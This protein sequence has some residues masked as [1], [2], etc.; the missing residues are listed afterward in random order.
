MKNFFFARLI[1]GTA[2]VFVLGGCASTK[3]I[4]FIREKKLS[5]ALTLPSE[6]DRREVLG[7]SRQ[8][9]AVSDEYGRTSYVMNAVRDDVTGEMTATETLDA[10]VLVARFRNVAERH[11]NIDMEFLIVVSDT[12]QDPAWQLRLDPLAVVLSD[13][14]RLEPVF[15]TGEDFRR[16]QIRGYD[17]YARYLQG[18]SRDSTRFVDHAQAGLF[19]SRAADVTSEEAA[20]HYTRRILK[21][22]NAR[23]ALRKDELR[24]R[25]ITSPIDPEFARLDSVCA[26][27]TAF[28]YLYSFA[29]P[30]RPGLRRIEVSLDGAI[31]DRS[32]LVCRLPRSESVTYYVS[33]LSSMAD[34]SMRYKRMVIP[35]TVREN[36]NVRLDF[37][38]GSS[39]VDSTLGNNAAVLASIRERLAAISGADEFA[40]DSLIVSA[41]CSPEGSYALNSL[42]A[43]R[44]SHSV[45]EYFGLSG[46]KVRGIAENWEMLDTLVRDCGFLSASSKGSY[47]SLA[48]VRSPDRREERLRKERYYP[49]VRDSLYPL[50]RHV[51]FRAHLHRKAQV[52][53]TVV[54]DVPDTAY[55]RGVRLL[56]DRNYDSAL[57]VLSPYKDYN[58]ALAYLALDYNATAAQILESLPG[59]PRVLYSLAISYSRRGRE[60]E[61]VEKLLE[62]VEKEPSYKY[63]GNLDPEIAAIIRKYNLFAP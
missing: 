35:R 33:S 41:S 20:R 8:S 16:A 26:G 44:R 45:R 39:E 36:V 52:Q 49:Q 58:A 18:L 23:K 11:G 61:A 2:A 29:L 46:A 42:L 37:A 57:A 34:S 60:K 25:Y 13:T 30:T 19:L 38:L 17:K 3:K 14:L 59:E 48:A 40:V 22:I 5:A 50:L 28:L 47:A 9:T 4:D 54:T 56:K 32:S 1:A 12:L 51:N 43:Q 27:K 63:R 55:M 62:A 6:K 15:I 53:D 21:K 7:S 24:H 10:A 31:Y